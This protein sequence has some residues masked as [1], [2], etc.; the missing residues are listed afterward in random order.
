[1]KTG[2]YLDEWSQIE[3]EYEEQQSVKVKA[4]I[5]IRHFYM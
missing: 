5:E 4:R 3:Y 2:Q 1:M